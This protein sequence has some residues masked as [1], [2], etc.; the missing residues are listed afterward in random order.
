MPRTQPPPNGPGRGPPN[1]DNRSRPMGPPPSRGGGN[2]GPRP[3]GPPPPGQHQ[4]SRSSEV[5]SD[6]LRVPG[7]PPPSRTP[8]A[9]DRSGGRPRSNSESSIAKDG[10]D[11]DKLR[12]KRRVERRAQESQLRSRE[13]ERD[14]KEGAKEGDKK[15][16]EPSRRKKNAPLDVIDKLDATGIYGGGCTCSRLP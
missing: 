12:E 8:S 15:P 14:K 5:G 9:T 11:V 4:H 10:S 2:F 3:R 13:R 7:R 16:A 6:G 1:G